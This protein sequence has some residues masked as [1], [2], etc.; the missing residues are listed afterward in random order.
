MQRLLQN[1]ALI[2]S[3]TCYVVN[4]SSHDLQIS[5]M[6]TVIMSLSLAGEMNASSVHRSTA[7]VMITSKFFFFHTAMAQRS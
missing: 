5:N 2:V 4:A 6:I 3:S 1:G 7:H